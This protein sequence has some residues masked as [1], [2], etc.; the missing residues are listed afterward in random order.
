MKHCLEGTIPM[1]LSHALLSDSMPHFFHCANFI[2]SFS[3]DL[4]VSWLC[5]SLESQNMRG[6]IFNHGMQALAVSVGLK[7]VE[8][9][10]ILG[11]KT[12]LC[13]S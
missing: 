4:L 3:K 12:F 7:S 6:T 11:R 9:I 13:I 5:A 8:I 1:K 10:N 2:C